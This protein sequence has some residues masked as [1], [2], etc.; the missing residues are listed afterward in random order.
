MNFQRERNKM[1]YFSHVFYL[2]P[3]RF[4]QILKVGTHWMWNLIKH[5]MNAY[6]WNLKKL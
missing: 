1:N 4:I 3:Y 6:T 2:Y 5:K